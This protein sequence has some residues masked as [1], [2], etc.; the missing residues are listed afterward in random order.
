MPEE[1][2]VEEERTIDLFSAELS[3]E[4]DVKLTKA[5]L[6]YITSV[7]DAVAQPRGYQMIEF[8]YNLM[9]ILTEL[10]N[11]TTP[12]SVQLEEKVESFSPAPVAAEE[13]P[14]EE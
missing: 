3:E 7:I 1:G 10:N 2:E 5:Q 14:A 6:L 9:G 13:S 4:I 11:Q 8:V 12:V